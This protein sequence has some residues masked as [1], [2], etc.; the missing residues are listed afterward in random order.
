[1]VACGHVGSEPWFSLHLAA[2]PNTLVPDS[3]MEWTLP[4]ANNNPPRRPQPDRFPSLFSLHQ[5]TSHFFYPTLEARMSIVNNNDSGK[6]LVHRIAEFHQPSSLI[7][8]V[9]LVDGNQS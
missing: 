2:L 1:M 3:M 6:S 5:Q 4:R 7:C 8:L 9:F